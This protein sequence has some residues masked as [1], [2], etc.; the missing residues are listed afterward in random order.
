MVTSALIGPVTYRYAGQGLSRGRDR[1]CRASPA[2]GTQHQL[3]SAWLVSLAEL[4]SAQ[5]LHRTW[6]AQLKLYCLPLPRHS[7]QGRRD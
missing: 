4:S 5:A 3:E 2:S 7:F 6:A 1:M